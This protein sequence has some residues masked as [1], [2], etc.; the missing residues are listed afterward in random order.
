MGTTTIPD[1]LERTPLKISMK[2]LFWNILE[3]FRAFRLLVLDHLGQG[4]YWVSL[5]WVNLWSPFGYI[6]LYFWVD[7]KQLNAVKLIIIFVWQKVD[8]GSGF[9]RFWDDFHLVKNWHVFSF[10]T[11]PSLDSERPL[12]FPVIPFQILRAFS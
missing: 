2:N 8:F 1:T 3:F 9:V 5:P 4:L 10:L 6:R 11:I 12:D 7:V